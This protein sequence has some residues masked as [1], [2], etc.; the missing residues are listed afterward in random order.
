M[1]KVMRTLRS[2]SPWQNAH[3]VLQRTSAG[4][5]RSGWKQLAQGINGSVADFR[6]FEPAR[7][8]WTCD[9]ASLS[10]REVFTKGRTLGELVGEAGLDA[11]RKQEIENPIPRIVRVLGVDQFGCEGDR[12]AGHSMTVAL[13]G[14]VRRI[15]VFAPAFGG[16]QYTSSR[17]LAFGKPRRFRMPLPCSIM[18]G[19]PQR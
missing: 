5:R 2:L 11:P 18:S 15:Y 6:S 12:I 4:A 17:M 10:K 9:S 7:A 8:A 14:E 13:G 3:R 1:A 19:C 16:I